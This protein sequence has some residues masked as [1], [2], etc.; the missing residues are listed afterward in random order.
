[1]K[2]A[3]V[4]SASIHVMLIAALFLFR[5]PLAQ[6]VRGPDAMQVAL[7][8]PS[9][10]AAARPQPSAPQPAVQPP[11]T[12]TEKDAVRIE[13]PKKAPERRREEPPP[14]E[15]PPAQTPPAAQ[16]AMSFTAIGNAGLSG[17]V[18]VDGP[19]FEFAYYLQLIRSRVGAV[20]SPPAGLVSAQP[21]RCVVS[22][23]ITR[24]GRIRGIALET[25][26]GTEFFDRAS[27]RAVQLSDPMAPLPAG[28]P[29]SELG[30]HFGFEYV[31]P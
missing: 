21:I 25:A 28:F 17:A 30:V 31:A 23:R 19:P 12:P 29:G 24:D 10:L 15:T 4:G 5:P 7:V 8:D 27:L 11:D 2:N 26:S 16:P 3:L 13:K 20:W 9:M 14:A 1:M 18:A 22:F 6:M